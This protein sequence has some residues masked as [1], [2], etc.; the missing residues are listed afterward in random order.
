MIDRDQV[1]EALDAAWGAAFDMLAAAPDGQKPDVQAATAAA[2]VAFLRMMARTIP[3]DQP[4]TVAPILYLEDVA[5]AVQERAARE[6]Q[7]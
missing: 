2:I 5:H 7:G 1:A 4:R 6:G 3:A